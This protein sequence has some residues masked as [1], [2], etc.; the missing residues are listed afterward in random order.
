MP[1]SRS[2][3]RRLDAVALSRE[4]RFDLLALEAGLLPRSDFIAMDLRGADFSNAELADFDFTLCDLRGTNLNLA[5]S[6]PKGLASAVTDQ[7]EVEFGS[8]AAMALRAMIEQYF[9]APTATKSL[10]RFVH[11]LHQTKDS[12]QLE[13]ATKSLLASHRTALESRVLGAALTALSREPGIKSSLVI[14]FVCKEMV[15]GAY[16]YRRA[17]TALE[18]CTLTE[19]AAVRSYLEDYVSRTQSSSATVDAIRKKLREGGGSEE[20]L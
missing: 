9:A 2:L 19:I 1:I 6:P 18:I 17:A 14:Q 16:P 5:S 13:F 10:L 3:A 11:F 8:L 15:A 7:V 4:T 20:G 12:K